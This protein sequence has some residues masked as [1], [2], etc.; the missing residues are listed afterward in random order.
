M[1]DFCVIWYVGDVYVGKQ[2]KY[3]TIYLLHLTRRNMIVITGLLCK[4]VNKFYRQIIIECKWRTKNP[5]TQKIKKNKKVEKS[6][7]MKAL[8]NKFINLIII[9]IIIIILCVSI[10]IKCDNVE[11]FSDTVKQKLILYWIGISINSFIRWKIC[12][13]IA[14]SLSK[15]AFLIECKMILFFLDVFF[16][17]C[18]ISQINQFVY[19]WNQNDHDPSKSSYMTLFR[20]FSKHTDNRRMK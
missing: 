2:M 15:Y 14:K 18:Q 12:N 19:V 4:Y 7:E 1:F 10:I 8:T 20:L 13:M 11:E 16:L 5:K 3:I 9:I 17:F 6:K